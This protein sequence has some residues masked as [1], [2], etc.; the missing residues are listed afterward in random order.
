MRVVEYKA[1]F[2]RAL[3]KLDPENRS[4]A[5]EVIKLFLLAVGANQIPA[6]MGLKRLQ[7]DHWEIR[8]DI[9]L[10]VCF[11]MRKDLIEFGIVGSHET[12]KNFL[13]NLY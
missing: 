8:I 4:R 9:H 1:S 5:K 6:G 7:D 10:R 11:R 13:K 3:K 12:I 2:V